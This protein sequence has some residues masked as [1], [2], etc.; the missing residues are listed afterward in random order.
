MVARD[1]PIGTRARDGPRPGATTRPGALGLPGYPPHPRYTP[2]RQGT[3]GGFIGS[4]PLHNR[5]IRSRRVRS[6]ATPFPPSRCQN[7]SGF[8]RTIPSFPLRALD[9]Q[10]RLAPYCVEI[11]RKWLNLFGKAVALSATTV[12]PPPYHRD[13]PSLRGRQALVS[14]EDKW[15]VLEIAYKGDGVR[16][17][18]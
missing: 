7:P 12:L 3:I 9:P 6:S 15:A 13:T 5:I 16:R 4:F 17:G 10:S 1:A 11:A 14:Q 18:G 2:F 8:P